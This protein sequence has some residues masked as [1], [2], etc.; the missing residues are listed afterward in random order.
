M[1]YGDIAKELK[2]I[3]QE[4]A[5]LAEKLDKIEQAPPAIAIPAESTKLN[6]EFLSITEAAEILSIS[7][8]TIYQLSHR[9]VFPSL[10]IGHR[11]LIPKNKLIDWINKHCGED[12]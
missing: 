10:R 7:R 6:K 4:L 1:R 5:E 3:A 2:C 12:I 9:D 11:I 8:S